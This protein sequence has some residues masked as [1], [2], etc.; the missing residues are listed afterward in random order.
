MTTKIARDMH[1]E[2]MD[3]G[4]L[5]VNLGGMNYHGS[6]G[7]VLRIACFDLHPENVLVLLKGHRVWTAMYDLEIC[8]EGW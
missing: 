7:L 6:T 1:D 2:P 8:N 4:D 3:T 5:V